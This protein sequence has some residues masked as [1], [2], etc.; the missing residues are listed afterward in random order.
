VC[1][2]L[3]CVTAARLAFE[4]ANPGD[5]CLSTSDNMAEGVGIRGKM[6]FILEDVTT[7]QSELAAVHS[8]HI[9]AHRQGCAPEARRQFKGAAR[10]HYP[11]N[12]RT[13]GSASMRE[14]GMRERIKSVMMFKLCYSTGCMQVWYG[15]TVNVDRLSSVHIA[16]ICWCLVKRCRGPELEPG[17]SIDCVTACSQ[18]DAHGFVEPWS[19]PKCLRLLLS[20][21]SRKSMK[22]S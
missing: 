14:W 21:C 15:V 2:K 22:C 9:A 5:Y 13:A 16:I 3:T 17:C 4:A 12:A 19:V 7:R 6:Q 20:A 1:D 10:K 8:L 11:M 18:V